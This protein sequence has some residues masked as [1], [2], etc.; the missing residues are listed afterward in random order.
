MRLTRRTFGLGAAFSLV[1]GKSIA[2]MAVGSGTLT[3]VS[4]GYLVLPADFTLGALPE[5]DRSMAREIAGITGDTVET[6]CNLTLYQDGERTIL[7][8]AGSGANFMPSAGTILD[9]LEAAGVAPED[10]TDVV[11]THAHPDHIWGVLDDFDEPLF[12]EATHHIG[13]DEVDYWLNPA[14]VDE[15]G[16]ARA[17]FAVGARNRLEAISDGLNTFSDGDTVVPGVVARATYGHTPGHMAFMVSD[18]ALIVGDAIGNGHLA[19]QKPGWAS[20]ADQDVEAGIV[21]RQALLAELAD[22]GL[23]MVGF[24]LPAGGLGRIEAAGDGYRFLEEAS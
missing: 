11:F 15:I 19:L 17:S 6:P 3:T 22:T 24:H 10:V 13:Q 8:D 21:T 7:F 20:G 9:S 14:T 16:E 18:T 23:L 4:D 5:A 2:R 1:A 12:S